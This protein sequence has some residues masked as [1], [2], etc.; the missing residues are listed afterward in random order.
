MAC[1]VSIPQSQ[2]FHHIEI[3]YYQSVGLKTFLQISI[4]STE[5]LCLSAALLLLLVSQRLLSVIKYVLSLAR[6]GP[7]RPNG[8]LNLRALVVCLSVP[9]VCVYVACMTRPGRLAKPNG[10]RMSYIRIGTGDR[11]RLKRHLIHGHSK[12]LSLN[13]VHYHIY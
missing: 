8:I 11:Q 6:V 10:F 4:A 2:T 3:A 12:L 5:L 7:H 13:H 1:S 9:R